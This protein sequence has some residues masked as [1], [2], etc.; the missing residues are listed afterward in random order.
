LYLV[1]ISIY[2]HSIS[3]HNLNDNDNH[4]L[5]IMPAPTLLQTIRHTIG[6]ALRETG[7]ALDRVGVRGKQHAV[8][9]RV[10]GDDPYIFDDHLSRHRNI[11][12]L[13]SRG[14]PRVHDKVAFIAPCSS[15]IGSVEVGEGSSIW[16]SAILKADRCN[17]GC[18][19]TEEEYQEWKNMNK[20]ER[21]N[22]DGGYDHNGSSGGIFIGNGTNIQDGCII[23]SVDDHTKIGD[24]V[25]VGHSAQIHSAIVEDNCLIGMGSILN[26]GS[27]VESMSLIAAGAVIAKN[28]VVK[29]GE[30]WVG[31]PAKKLRDL[32]EQEKQRLVFQADEYIKLASSQ[33][34]A[35]ELGGNISD[36]E[37][38]IVLLGTS[39]DEK[40]K[41]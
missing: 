26:P 32:T 39:D 8:T 4:N 34:G 12:P 22:N 3:N 16:Y 17:M 40:E 24:N 9:R 25:T 6:R 20:D 10:L 37:M 31:N 14:Q 28:E 5:N 11:M 1:P 18:G 13:L 35:M 29:S 21:E 38:D 2:I 27:R 30:L 41:E 7:Q 19:R 36:R 15:L 33:S 23:T